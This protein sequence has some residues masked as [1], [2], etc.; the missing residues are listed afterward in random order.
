MISS[1]FFLTTAGELITYK[2][3]T[4]LKGACAC[5][6]L[7]LGLLYKQRGSSLPAVVCDAEDGVYYTF[8]EQDDVVAVAAS[9]DAHASTVL[10]INTLNNL[11][12]LFR[13]VA[14]PLNS[15]NTQANIGLLNEVSLSVAC[16]IGNV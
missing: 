3:V 11:S 2:E 6:P 10:V 16:G 7:K 8:S 1:I 14:G 12:A 13:D 15:S 5:K 4:P 9:D